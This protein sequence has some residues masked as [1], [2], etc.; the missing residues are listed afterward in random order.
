MEAL[1]PQALSTIQ[2][3]FLHFGLGKAYA[4]LGR[5]D[6]FRHLLEAN[7]LQ[8]QRITYD[9]GATLGLLQR[10]ADAFNA[11][12]MNAKAGL[13]D[14]SKVPIFI[15]GMPRSGS[16]LV[17]QVLA[18]HPQMF[19]AD[20]ITAFQN[21][22]SNLEGP[23][24]RQKWGTSES[25]ASMT[26]EQ[27]RWVGTQYVRHIRTMAPNAERI[28]NKALGN[29]LLVGLIH[30]TLPKAR[31][32]HVQRDP[33]D[34]CVSCFSK[35]FV[36]LHHY[37]YDLAELG[38]YYRGYEALMEHWRRV[39]PKGVMLDVRYENLIDDFEPQARR[40]VAHCGLDWDPHCL[41]FHRTE[42]TVKTASA[43]QVRQPIY[44]S[45]VGRWLDFREFLQPLLDALGS[46][47]PAT[48]SVDAKAGSWS[49]D[50]FDK[51]GAMVEQA[52]ACSTATNTPTA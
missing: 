27:L 49:K 29:F 30:L 5:Q 22:A 1:D 44:R 51:A 14:H 4:D 36:N 50:Q 19:G 28:T 46:R 45:S 38:R 26:G 2:R 31:V 3:I 35:W 8:R 11:D 41:D 9:E 18:S 16:T 7:R 17:E 21:V 15:V 12:L 6:A 32:I 33:I 20:E 42:R 39:L 40:L 10:A 43:A 25:L 37:A 47:A 52:A 34:T 24:G 23:Q 48:N 13:G